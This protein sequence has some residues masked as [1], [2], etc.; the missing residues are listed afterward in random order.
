[1]SFAEWPP[2]NYCYFDVNNTLDKPLRIYWGG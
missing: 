2:S 1:M